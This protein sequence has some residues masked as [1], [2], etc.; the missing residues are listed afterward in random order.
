MDICHTSISIAYT[1]TTWRQAINGHSHVLT[2][3][4]K[5]GN[6]TIKIAKVKKQVLIGSLQIRFKVIWITCLCEDSTKKHKPDLHICHGS[7]ASRFLTSW[8]DTTLDWKTRLHSTPFHKDPS[9]RFSSKNGK[10][11]TTRFKEHLKHG[12]LTKDGA[13]NYQQISTKNETSTSDTKS[14]I[15]RMNGQA[16][17]TFSWTTHSPKR[18][19]NMSPETKDPPQMTTQKKFKELSNICKKNQLNSLKLCLC[20]TNGSKMTIQPNLKLLL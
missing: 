13:Y 10:R 12:S 14:Q 6:K 8:P 18:Q 1:T 4:S 15:W 9:L 16:N 3:T 19:P 11:F 2:K 7:K 17:Q 5:Q 20:L